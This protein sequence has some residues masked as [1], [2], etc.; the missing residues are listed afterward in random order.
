MGQ[1][2][3]FVNIDKRQVLAH[4]SG[5]KLL[6]M[7]ADRALEPLVG[8]LRR[9]QWVPY[10]APSYAIQSSKQKSLE[11][12]VIALPQEV[13]EHI[14]SLLVEDERAGGPDLICL[15][16]TCS[17]FFRL[18][19]SRVQTLLAEDEAPWAGDRLIF[20]GDYANGIPEGVL[21]EAERRQLL[22]K[23]HE[24]VENDA[25]GPRVVTDEPNPLY[26]SIE[27][28]FAEK[29]AVFEWRNDPD[30]VELSGSLLSHVQKRIGSTPECKKDINLIPGFLQNMPTDAS[31]NPRKKAVLLRNLT[32]KEF[33]L[34]DT[35]AQGSLKY[36]L[37]EVLGTFTVWTE[38]GSGTE[39]LQ[40]PGRWAGHRFD[41]G[42]LE[43][44]AGEGWK[45]VSDE[46]AQNLQ[47]GE[48]Y[49]YGVGR[50]AWE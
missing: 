37:G 33:V 43:D 2:W 25:P 15:S 49:D 19:G 14:V 29:G 27:Q 16:L 32:T 24:E 11:S 36:S 13:I 6:E 41:I 38:D 3:K 47:D 35:I 7:L 10:I 39:S 28:K 18:L 9:P 42:C 40:I 5:L 31:G 30:E 45:N 44:V 8:L 26:Y 23:A 48:L 12:P 1:Y 34:D 20:V 21:N 4:E 22:G 17:Y 46:A 50:R